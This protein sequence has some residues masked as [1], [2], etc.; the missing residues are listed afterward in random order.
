MNT[1]TP[2]VKSFIE[3]I[4]L[5]I[6]SAK[7]ALLTNCSTE[8]L[9]LQNQ[10]IETIHID[11]NGCLWSLVNKPKQQLAQFH[12]HFPVL[13]HYFRKGCPVSV[14]VK[15]TASIITDPETIAAFELLQDYGRMGGEKSDFSTERDYC[16]QYKDASKSVLLHVVIETAAIHELNHAPSGAG[17]AVTDWFSN[18]IGRITREKRLNL[19]EK[20]WSFS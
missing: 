11:E 20:K 2:P 18:L 6:L 15:G 5:A 1:I 12:P 14:E 17:V 10:I 13:L 3:A 16:Q 8:V 4:K 9:K 19:Y 7:T